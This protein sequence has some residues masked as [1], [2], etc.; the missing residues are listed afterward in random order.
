MCYQRNCLGLVTGCLGAQRTK[1]WRIVQHSLRITTK[2][3]Q[4]S[5][6]LQNGLCGVNA[7]NLI[8]SWVQPD[9]ISALQGVPKF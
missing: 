2:A 5:R 4:E 9:A 3:R 7:L 1:L 6:E 8:Q